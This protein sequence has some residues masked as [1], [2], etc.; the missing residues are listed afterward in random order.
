MK[1][2]YAYLRKKLRESDALYRQGN[3]YGAR[4]ELTI[5]R[6]AAKELEQDIVRQ[7]KESS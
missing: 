4:T 5:L 1:K 7:I 6:Q 3:L 2:K